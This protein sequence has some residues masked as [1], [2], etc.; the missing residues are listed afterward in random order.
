MRA[1][2]KARSFGQVDL[3]VAEGEG[4]YRLLKSRRVGGCCQGM[5]VKAAL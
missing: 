2:D 3:V 5:V 4:E 1:V